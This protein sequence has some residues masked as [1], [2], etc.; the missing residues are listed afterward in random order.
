MKLAL[1]KMLHNLSALTD[2][3]AEIS[4]THNFEEVMRASLHTLL[5]TLAIPKGAIAQ[6][7]ARPRML[8]IMAAK[9]LP[10]AL[11]EQIQLGRDE[12][13]KL[14]LRGRPLE[15]AAERN[16]LSRFVGR[17]ADILKRLRAHTFVPMVV[18]GELEGVIF[19]SEKFT[20]EPFTEDDTEL[21][22]TISRHI[23]IAF[24]N[25]RLLVSLRRKAEENRK[26]YNDMRQMY[27]DTIKAFG[28]A[29]DLKDA[30]TKG[31]SDRVARYSEA[32]A[33]EMGITGTSLEYIGVAGYLHDIG[34]IVVDRS[35]I[36]NP[37]PLTDRE[38]H[39][40]NRHVT[41]G[42][43]IL[44][45]INHPWKEIAYLTK[46]HHEKVDG[47]GYPQ[48]LR[49]DEIPL[50]SKIVTLADSFD[51]MMTDRPYRARLPLDRALSD[52]RRNAGTQF[53]SEVVAAFCR[54]LLKEINGTSRERVF[55]PVIGLKFDR[56]AVTATLSSMIEDLDGRGLQV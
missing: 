55:I 49:G 20:K 11:G 44:S 4:S 42:Y 43:E 28:A 51:A 9:G 18:H 2:L 23:G 31:H 35:I 14:A 21:I 41:T 36:N 46:C 7:S 5:G 17:N 45:N 13:K 38:F 39:E 32:I 8:K 24:Y 50:G 16:G 54:L 40:L 53:A 27:Q 10:S 34:K 15:V 47:T 3:G 19:L 48:G 37:R 6:F 30:Y 1:R 29:I 12:V 56:E 22:N 52:L 26:L 33:K 25:H